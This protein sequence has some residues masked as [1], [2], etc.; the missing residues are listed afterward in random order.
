MQSVLHIQK[1]GNERAGNMDVAA[2]S[3]AY[4]DLGGE[5][6]RGLKN[7]CLHRVCKIRNGNENPNKPKPK[8]SIFLLREG[9]KYDRPA[10]T[11]KDGNEVSSCRKTMS[12]DGHSPSFGDQRLFKPSH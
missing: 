4:V 1:K 6:K 8:T 2:E 7:Q 3:G 5:E 10:I 9:G 11:G 12:T